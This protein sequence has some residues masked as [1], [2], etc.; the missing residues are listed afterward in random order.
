M[1]ICLIL[2]LGHN[3]LKSVCKD[4]MLDVIS[5][6]PAFSEAAPQGEITEGAASK[7]K[8]RR[9]E[10]VGSFLSGLGR[11]MEMSR[12]GNLLVS[13][14]ELPFFDFMFYSTSRFKQDWGSKAKLGKGAIGSVFRSRHRIDGHEYAI[15]RIKFCFRNK[16]EL[17]QTY[18]KVIREVKLLASLDHPNIVRYNK[19]WFEPSWKDPDY[20]EP[21]NSDDDEEDDFDSEKVDD[22]ESN[23]N[24][25]STVNSGSSGFANIGVDANIKR[26]NE[27]IVR[28]MFS[29][30]LMKRLTLLL[31]S[32]RACRSIQITSSLNVQVMAIL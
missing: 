14:T 22:F 31:P 23:I 27:S 4:F 2:D 1:A 18:A 26:A 28:I 12:R 24:D 7:S 8:L 13:S 3:C 17:E 5:N 32:P 16:L 9:S 19:A 29:L 25:G 30:V 10:S 15:K 20:G 21:E 11:D 6:W